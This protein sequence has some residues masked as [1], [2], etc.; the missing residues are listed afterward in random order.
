MVSDVDG[1]PGWIIRA[2]NLRPVV[3]DLDAFRAGLAGDPLAEPIELL[4]TGNAGAALHVLELLQQTPRVR[5]LAADCHRDLG[6]TALAV[7]EYD[8]LVAESLGTAREAVLRQHRGKAL[9]ANGEAER[10]IEDFQQ[11]V[12]LRR[13]ADTV[14]LDSA[15]QALVVARGRVTIR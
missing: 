15:E 3:I 5:A 10:A 6:D 1:G 8:V 7:G 9:L 14:L 12:E 11:A 4:W 2:A 13:T